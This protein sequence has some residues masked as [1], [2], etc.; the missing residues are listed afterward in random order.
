MNYLKD[1]WSTLPGGSSSSFA[2]GLIVGTAGLYALKKYSEGGVC[3]DVVDL[4]SK[5]VI[6][7]GANTGIG[8]E[9]AKALAKMNAR[10]ILA[11]RPSEKTTQAVQTIKNYSKNDQV[12]EIPLDLTSLKSIR[13]FVEQFKSKRLPLHIL[14]N[15]AGVMMTPE[16]KTQDGFE[17]QMGT[18][19]LGHFLL[20][21]LLLDKIIE[22]KGRIVNLSSLA[23]VGAKLNLDNLMLENN[24]GSILA[25]SN[26]KAAN[27]LFTIE[28]QRRLA[29][30]GV[31]A[32]SVH[33]GSV[34]S[35]LSRSFNPLVRGIL[36]VGQILLGKN[37]VQGAQTSIYAAISPSLK[38]KG[39]S[40]LS[41]CK[42]TKASK[43]ASDP[44]LA[45]KLWEL[46]NKLVGLTSQP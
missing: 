43:H 35:E 10:V 37:A 44:E 46:S 30:T 18:N 39:G 45:K 26:S 20:T 31:E 3:N 12:E 11:C 23:H 24:Y 5:V 7:T 32:F 28:L 9:T 29:G 15:N 42:I 25:Y 8:L 16:L 2:T 36:F 14:I 13:S 40:Y 1:I 4:T 22:T 6:I 27:I 38:G 17:L 34:Q 33:P 21:N 41:D 19:H